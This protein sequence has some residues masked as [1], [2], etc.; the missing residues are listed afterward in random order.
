MAIT[1]T[2]RIDNLWFPSEDQNKPVQNIFYTVIASD[3]ETAVE[4]S[5]VFNIFPSENEEFIAY[6]QLSEEIVLNWLL[7]ALGKTRREPIE[8]QLKLELENIKS[9]PSLP[10]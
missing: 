4:H 8:N 7:E 2:Y 10:W 1:Y 6:E 3:G 5:A 9:K